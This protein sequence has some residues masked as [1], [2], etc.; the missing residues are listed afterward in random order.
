MS[1]A[2]SKLKAEANS[3]VHNSQSQI[4]T[5]NVFSPAL[6][7]QMMAIPGGFISAIPVAAVPIQPQ[8]QAI[9]HLP[10]TNTTTNVLPQ[11][12][13]YAAPHAMYNSNDQGR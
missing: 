11:Q 10:V 6:G 8:P 3:D 5:T 9:Y 12:T 13:V 2:T 4:S 7:V 1:T